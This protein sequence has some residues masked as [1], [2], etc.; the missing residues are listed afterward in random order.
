[1]NIK[2]LSY[3]NKINV[4]LS[5]W[6]MMILMEIFVDKVDKIEETIQIKKK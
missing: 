2:K 4:S 3:T 6:I 5:P 1:M